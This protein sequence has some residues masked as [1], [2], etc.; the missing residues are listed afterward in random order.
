VEGR[1]EGRER[2]EV[3]SN[4]EGEELIFERALGLG[5]E[6]TLVQRSLRDGGSPGAWVAGN[7]G[8]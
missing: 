4:E 8:G 6:E 2:V 3:T 5:A 7:E 1:V